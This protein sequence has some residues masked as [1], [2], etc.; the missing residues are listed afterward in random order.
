MK[1]TACLL[2]VLAY[3]AGAAGAQRKLLQYGN[4][5]EPTQPFGDWQSISVASLSGPTYCGLRNFPP[6]PNGYG[7]ARMLCGGSTA[8]YDPYWVWKITKVR[9][10]T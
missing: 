3:V 9:A 7:A 10:T 6:I 5:Y 4:N 8:K 1:T 2:L